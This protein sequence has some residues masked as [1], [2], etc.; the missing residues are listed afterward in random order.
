M[1]V[2]QTAQILLVC[3]NLHFCFCNYLWETES[4]PVTTFRSFHIWRS[5]LTGNKY[6]EGG[7]HLRG[8]KEKKV[9]I[10]FPCSFFNLLF[11]C[12]LFYA[13]SRESVLEKGLADYKIWNHAFSFPKSSELFCCSIHNC[14]CELVFPENLSLET[15]R[16]VLV[17]SMGIELQSEG[18]SSWL[19]RLFPCRA[20]VVLQLIRVF[21]F[22]VLQGSVC[23]AKRTFHSLFPYLFTFLLPSR[24]VFMSPVWT[25]LVGKSA[26]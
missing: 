16:T 6:L 7:M 8:A 9:Q 20:S 24:T 19:N 25:F 4:L 5:V 18:W 10:H 1:E 14:F 3:S 22:R 26:P 12:L 11:L 15:L 2:L 17:G 23:W 13:W 21:F